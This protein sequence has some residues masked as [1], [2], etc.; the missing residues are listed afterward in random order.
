MFGGHPRAQYPQRIAHHR[1][2]RLAL[3]CTRLQRRAVCRALLFAEHEVLH[4][5]VDQ[6]HDVF[7][8]LR[9]LCETVSTRTA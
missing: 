3:R 2:G 5:T 6:R 4:Q 8:L 1:I 9:H 7:A